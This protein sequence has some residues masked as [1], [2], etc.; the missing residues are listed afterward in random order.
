MRTETVSLGVA[1]NPVETNSEDVQPVMVKRV[2]MEEFMRKVRGGGMGH[3]KPGCYSPSS[4]T[5]RLL[6]FV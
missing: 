2:S 6:P 3:M 1:G 5:L 4:N